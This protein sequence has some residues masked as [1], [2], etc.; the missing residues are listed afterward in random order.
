M[1]HHPTLLQR[2]QAVLLIID[3]QE[4]L[5]KAM[6]RRESVE[7]AIL[8]LQ[9]GMEILGIPTLMTEQYPKGLGPTVETIRSCAGNAC[10]VEKTAFSCCGEANFWPELERLQPRQVIVTGM[11]AHVCVL[12]TVLD[13]LHAGFQVHVPV[14]AVCSRSDAHRDNALRRME[15]AGAILTNVE[16]ALFELVRGAHSPEFKAISKL[17]V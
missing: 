6:A 15:Q 3:V 1:E 17:V 10:C 11:E 16:S 4:R 13:L 8:K 5:V 9:Q 2:D 7:Q 12:Q 14:C